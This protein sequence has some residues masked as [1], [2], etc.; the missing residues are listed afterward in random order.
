MPFHNSSIDFFVPCLSLYISSLCPSAPPL[1]MSIF[2]KSFCRK[3]LSF[4][5]DRSHFFLVFC[6]SGSFSSLFLTH[7]SVPLLSLSCFF[8]GVEGSELFPPRASSCPFFHCLEVRPFPPL[9][10]IPCFMPCR[11]VFSFPKFLALFFCP[12]STKPLD[13]RVLF[14][15]DPPPA[16]CTPPP[17]RYPA[18][19]PFT[20]K[21]P[22]SERCLQRL[23]FFFFLNLF[24]LVIHC[25][26][27]R[28][29][30]GLFSIETVLC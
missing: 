21:I 13:L 7:R 25:Y 11:V 14:T 6:A 9:W 26:S 10:Q 24:R 17:L 20:V 15:P 2:D 28:P 16:S 1:N 8:L 3:S 22:G 18:K 30:V 29:I 5:S 12:R 4:S 19:L 23:F 27:L